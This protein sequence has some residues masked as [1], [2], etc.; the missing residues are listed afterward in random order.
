M[1][2]TLGPLLC[3]PDWPSGTSGL[4][5]RPSY[6]DTSEQRPEVWARLATP[7]VRAKPGSEAWLVPRWRPQPVGS[8][9][10][11]LEQEE[12]LPSPRLLAPRS[13]GSP[14]GTISDHAPITA[15]V[16]PSQLPSARVGGTRPPLGASAGPAL[17]VPLTGVPSCSPF[18]GFLSGPGSGAHGVRWGVRGLFQVPQPTLCSSCPASFL[19]DGCDAAT[20]GDQTLAISRL[21][22][23][24]SCRLPILFL[25]PQLVAGGETEAGQ[26]SGL[27]QGPRNPARGSLSLTQ[28]TH[29]VEQDWPCAQYALPP[30]KAQW[31]ANT[32]DLPAQA[33][34]PGSFPG[35][36]W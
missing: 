12:V 5:L 16:S 1:C 27:P 31:R 2:W 23:V 32:V 9:S 3:C 15:L 11:G 14:D 7:W 36:G 10:R 19:G 13:L 35:W 6:P 21:D 22:L 24:P 33:A 8:L 34:Q 28:G 17:A 30:G 4:V 20:T 29:P 18:S 25:G 26:A